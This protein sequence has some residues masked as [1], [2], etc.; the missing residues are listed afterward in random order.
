MDETI[1]INDECVICYD[2]ITNKE[3]IEPCKHP[4]HHQCFL[5]TKTNTCPVCRQLVTCPSVG[6]HVDEYDKLIRLHNNSV[7]I[8]IMSIYA[9]L[10]FLFFIPKT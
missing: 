7:T 2:A 1:P 6:C 5:M 9:I 4:V 10:L 3:Y 8:F